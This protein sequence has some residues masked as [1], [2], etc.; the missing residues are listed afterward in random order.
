MGGMDG[1]MAEGKC[2]SVWTRGVSQRVNYGDTDIPG[3]NDGVLA[4]CSLSLWANARSVGSILSIAL[5]KPL[6]SLPP[7]S[8]K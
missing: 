1:V 3:T 8:L 7:P 2:C 6:S 4:W 5:I